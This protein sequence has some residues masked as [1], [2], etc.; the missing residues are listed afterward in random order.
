MSG[1]VVLIPAETMGHG[2]DGLG[3]K[4]MKAFLYALGEADEAPSH[5]LLYNGGA[6]LSQEGAETVEDLKKL[7]DKGVE[8]MTCG[9]C[10]E[11]YGIS[12]KVAVG[13]I[14]NM[15]EIVEICT[16]ADSVIRP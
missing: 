9:T 12:D 10:T 11:F 16:E 2:D 7:A 5:V 6:F 15:Y 14:T 4:L 13:S 3:K 1:K 8:V